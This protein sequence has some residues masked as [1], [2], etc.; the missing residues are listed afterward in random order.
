MSRRRGR[1]RYLPSGFPGSCRLFTILEDSATF[2][3]SYGDARP[4]LV[5][6]QPLATLENVDEHGRAGL[7]VAPDDAPIRSRGFFRSATRGIR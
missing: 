2:S 7:R 5:T 3:A 1:R 4:A 6:A